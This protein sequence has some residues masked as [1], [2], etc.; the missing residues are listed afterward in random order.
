MNRVILADDVVLEPGRQTLASVVAG[1]TVTVVIEPSRALLEQ[2]GV[3]ASNGVHNIAAKVPFKMMMANFT[4]TAASLHKNEIVA[5]L[6]TGPATLIKSQTISTA[7]VFGIELPLS[8][9]RIPSPEL[10][11][12][13]GGE[14]VKQDDKHPEEVRCLDL[15]HVQESHHG[16]IREML[17]K[18]KDLWS[19]QL[20]EISTADHRIELIPGARPVKMQP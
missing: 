3:A 1:R 5:F 16:A 2:F 9:T 4:H 12:E 19:G 8:P 6:L 20:G 17:S 11:K 18:H 7:E 13:K 14:S 10:E 15:S